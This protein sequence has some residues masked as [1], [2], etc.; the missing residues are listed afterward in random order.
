MAVGVGILTVSDGCA[1][2]TATDTSGPALEKLLLEQQK[3][4]AVVARRIVSDNVDDISGTVQEWTTSGSSLFCRLVVVTGGTGLS[5]SDVTIEALEP[6]FTKRLPALATAMVIGSLRITPMAAL[7]QV[8]AGVIGTTVVLAVPG[9][10]KGATEN[11]SQVLSVLPHAVDTA[12]AVSGTRH[13]HAPDTAA[14]VKAVPRGPSCG[15]TRPED[16]QDTQRGAQGLSDDLEGGVTRRARK[17]PYPMIAVDKALDLVLSNI[18]MMEAKELSL[19]EIRQGQVIAQDVVAQENVPGYRASIMDGYAVVASDGPGVFS[20]RGSSTAGSTRRMVDEENPLRAGEVVRVATGAPVPPGA[21]AVVMIEDTELVESTAGGSEE[22]RVRV[23]DSVRLSSGQNIRPIGHDLPR[24]A[25]VLPKGTRVSAVGGEIGT[26]AISGC[27][28]FSVHT[29]PRIAVMSTG[30]EVVDTL[31]APVSELSYGAIR[32][33]NRPA[34]LAA[35]AAIGCPTVD[36]GVIKD[37]P[38]E[39]ERTIRQA[40]ETCEGVITTGGVSM[41]EKDWLKPVVEQR[42]GGKIQFG[43]VMMKPSKPTTFA[44]LPGGQKF[45]FALPGNPVSALVAFHMFAAPAIRKLAGHLLGVP[46]GQPSLGVLRPSVTAS[47]DGSPV[48][49]DRVRPEY[50]R[51]ALAWNHS[52][53]SWVVRIVDNRQQSSRMASMQGANALVAL[54]RGSAQKPTVAGGELVT[55]I[56]IDTPHF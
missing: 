41:G 26:L 7:S 25:L 5:P 18:T 34:I 15:C 43:R 4:W 20:V 13:L 3:D 51:G 6:L 28:A 33:S 56:I 10:R 54:P 55:A 32:D 38:D 52:T 37:S 42:L 24:G 45:I 17:S 16:T 19:A 12:A 40:L 49:L 22:L 36:L 35:L 44:T 30:D 39:L 21:D 50:V 47:F 14:P 31:G 11:V 9:S 2:G 1:R 27:S 46:E 29:L 53:S 23:L 8:A 48:V